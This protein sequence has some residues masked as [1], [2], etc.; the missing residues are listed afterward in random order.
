VSAG[1]G[2]VSH[3]E[4]KIS[5]EAGSRLD[6]AILALILARAPLPEILNALC[7]EV[8]RQ[9][10]GL[11]CSVLLLEADGVTLRSGAAP[12]LPPEYC[13]AIDGAKS[14]PTAGSCGTAVYRREQ[15]VVSDIATD[16]LWA[17]YRQFALP[18]GLRACWSTPIVV[19]DGAIFGTFAIY[20]REPR[21]PDA[22]HL[23]I[24]AHATHLAGIAIE[25]DR[26]QTQL[27]AA[28]DRYR[29]LVERLPA[30]TYIAELGAGGQWHYVSPQIETILGFLPQEWLADPMSW[31]NRIHVDDR[32]IALAAE[33][34]FQD[35]HELF[36][37]EYRMFARDGRVLWF[38]DEAVMLQ[39]TEDHGLQMQGVLYDI[40]AHKR[41]EDE[42]RHS[43]KMEAVGQLAGGVAHDF[44]NLLMVIRARNERLQDRL[45]PTDPAHQD[46]VEIEHA[47]TRA[48]A[49][50][51]QLLAFGRK[52]IL[53]TK[54]LDLN[55]VMVQVVKMLDRLIANNIELTTL[56]A[57]SLGLVKA[58][59][60]QIEQVIL[61][62]AVN[63]RD[64]MP[65]GGR[66][67]LE[68]KNVEVQEGDIQSP[69][70]VP[71]G[72]YVMLSVSDT[73]VGMDPATQAHMFEPFFTTKE[74]GKG[75][76][77]GLATVYGVV[78]QMDGAIQVRSQPGAGSTFEIYLPRVESGEKV[79]AS[80]T[81]KLLISAPTG[82]ETI[83]LVE[84]QD[85]IRDLVREFLQRKGYTVLVAVDGQDGLRIAAQQEQPIH[86]L[87]TDVIMPTIGGRELASR[88]RQLHPRMK[89][90]FMS[91][92]AEPA[93]SSTE[94]VFENAP[95]LQKPF[96]LDALAHKVRSVLDDS[97]S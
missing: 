10:T 42:L 64:A 34:R 8:E 83:L 46:A 73:G 38:R 1:V 28:E 67:I 54:V 44:N 4:H 22:G 11:L 45:A 51:R 50:T 74:A 5:A 53:H 3:K 35:T 75:T 93:T 92:Y 52:Q 23:Q 87:L 66:L 33:K 96:L 79:D 15:V 56:Q 31:M 62:L 2:K 80:E 76:G 60:G 9:N 43:Q 26:A 85:G 18:H 89:V 16:P 57:P 17:E 14:G 30:I 40:T 77:L 59:P 94:A 25:H 6:E 49:L 88:L 24:I 69:D 68:T 86:L 12:S 20:Y 71:A 90:L 97:T 21:T 32:E 78:N 65:Q 55:V 63:A 39:E 58:D 72:K 27:R 19:Q 82:S 47:V 41:L 84:D 13:Q 37:A 91:G 29:T 70:A 95:V 61:N 81:S 48:A 7:V 36:Q